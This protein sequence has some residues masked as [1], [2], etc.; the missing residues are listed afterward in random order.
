MHRKSSLGP[1][2]LLVVTGC[3]FGEERPELDP[4][5][6]LE[7]RLLRAERVHIEYALRSEGALES[8]ATGTLQLLPAKRIEWTSEGSFAGRAVFP[9]LR[10]NGTRVRYGTENREFD[11]VEPPFLRQAIV[12]GVTRMG[13]LHNQVRMVWSQLPDHAEGGLS[14]WLDI[15]E[16]DLGAPEL[17]DEGSAAPLRFGL[18]VDGRKTADVTLWLDTETGLPRRRDQVVDFSG[19]ESMQVTETYARFEIEDPTPQ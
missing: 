9:E 19:G 5:R 6:K 2:V 15:T 4:V 17:L 16:P 1:L 13:L 18:L 11:K 7:L 10:S 8:S 3:S 14:T 12:I